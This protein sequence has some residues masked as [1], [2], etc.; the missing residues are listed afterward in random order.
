MSMLANKLFLILF[1]GFILFASCKQDKIIKIVLIEEVPNKSN[2]LDSIVLLYR[3]VDTNTVFVS[4]I[5]HLK[6]SKVVNEFYLRN[7]YKKTEIGMYDLENKLVFQDYLSSSVNKI[8]DVYFMR[9]GYAKANMQ[10]IGVEKVNINGRFL[11]LRKYYGNDI[12]V[13]NMNK[14]YY[15]FDE[16]NH[17][18]LIDAGWAKIIAKDY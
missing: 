5:T 18:L 1:L 15:Y 4:K 3:I 13:K 7:N 2:S 6:K 11:S 16:H 12:G 14:E 9:W 17:L 8:C 10:F